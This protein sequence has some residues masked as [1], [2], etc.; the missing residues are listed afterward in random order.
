MRRIYIISAASVAA[1]VVCVLVLGNR[2]TAA[3]ATNVSAVK[4]AKQSARQ[5]AGISGRI[6]ESTADPAKLAERKELHDR[7]QKFSQKIKGMG[8]SG[9]IFLLAKQH[10]ELGLTTEQIKQVQDIYNEVQIERLALEGSL[11]KVVSNQNDE[12]HV[13][14]PAYP[15]EG[16]KLRE[17]LYQSINQMAGADVAAKVQDAMGVRIANAMRSFGAAEQNIFATTETSGLLDIVH[18]STS[19]GVTKTVSSRLSRKNLDQYAAFETLIT[20][21]R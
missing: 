20:Q 18:T 13:V 21:H 16:E 7:V 10:T 5:M 19:D 2:N 9:D 11:A 6:S 3:S 8:F 12:I 1:F 15:E 4:T 17:A 14:V